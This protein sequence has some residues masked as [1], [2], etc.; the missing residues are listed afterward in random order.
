MQGARK[1]LEKERD[2]LEKRFY[3]KIMRT[4]SLEYSELK[5]NGTMLCSFCSKS[6]CMWA[7]M[8]FNIMLLMLL[9]CHYVFF[10][11]K[12]LPR[13]LSRISLKALWQS[14]HW[15]VLQNKKNSSQYSRMDGFRLEKHKNKQIQHSAQGSKRVT[16]MTNDETEQLQGLLWPDWEKRG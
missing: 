11:I 5:L 8:F 3:W 10:N 1:K 12:M 13:K 7:Q 14:Q 15:I 6:P 16:N 2:E 9:E 4:N